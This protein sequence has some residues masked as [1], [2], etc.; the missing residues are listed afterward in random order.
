MKKT[1]L[2]LGVAVFVLAFGTAYGEER[3]VGLQNGITFY[4]ALPAP[5]IFVE[6]DAGVLPGNGV[7]I[8]ES[9]MAG[10][11]NWLAKSAS[12]SAAGGM[13]AE[14]IRPEL[15]NGV[16]VFDSADTY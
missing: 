10:H 1:L 7:T 2:I 12:G 9:G 3:D 6:A 11:A 8:F 15:Y 16:T 14:G 4:E 5:T 13:S